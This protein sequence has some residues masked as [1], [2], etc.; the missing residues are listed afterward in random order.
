[1]WEALRKTGGFLSWH[2]PRL[3]QTIWR[4]IPGRR[5]ILSFAL[6]A[7]LCLAALYTPLNRWVGG[8]LDSM[9]EDLKSRAAFQVIDDFSSGVSQHWDG[10]GLV[11]DAPGAARVAG[12]ALNRST[13]QLSGYRLDFDARI[14]TR[15]LGWV[16]GASDEHN[17]SA[18]KLEQVGSGDGTQYRLVRYQVTEGQAADAERVQVDVPL[19]LNPDYNH[20]SVRLRENRVATFING[21]GVDYWQAPAPPQGGI[22]FFTEGDESAL[23][24]RVEVS[25]NDDN[26]GLFLYGLLE[27]VQKTAGLA[28]QFASPLQALLTETAA[29]ASPADTVNTNSAQ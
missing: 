29:K 2:L 5:L 18:F 21:T 20:V 13:M 25:G 4:A 16:I 19:A 14:A 22:G 24:R 6:V 17:Y 28:E 10:G 26:M 27:L 15:G 3:P 23:L 11:S 9:V 1:M 7:S 12:F 8:P